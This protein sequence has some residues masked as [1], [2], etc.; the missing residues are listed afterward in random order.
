MSKYEGFYDEAEGAH[1]ATN[2]Q[3]PKAA[4]AAAAAAGKKGKKK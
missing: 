1:I 2:V 4:P 3:A